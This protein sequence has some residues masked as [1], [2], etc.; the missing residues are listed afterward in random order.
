MDSRKAILNPG[1]AGWKIQ[2]QGGNKWHAM[3]EMPEE[4][5]GKH[6][7]CGQYEAWQMEQYVKATPTE[8]DKQRNKR[9]Q[10]TN[11]L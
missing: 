3:R 11:S 1:R 4:L 5:Q 2:N 6:E 7:A 10:K 9:V 8:S